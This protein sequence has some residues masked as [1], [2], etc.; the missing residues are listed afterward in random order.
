MDAQFLAVSTVSQFRQ[1][2]SCPGKE[3]T[4]HNF[5]R[6]YRRLI[7]QDSVQCL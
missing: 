6:V 5:Q 4:V 3:S 7:V 2:V 1:L